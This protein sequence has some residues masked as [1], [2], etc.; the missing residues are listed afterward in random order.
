MEVSN[1]DSSLANGP[2]KIVAAQ[3]LA[4][5]FTKVSDRST[6]WFRSH[7]SEVYNCHVP[8]DDGAQSFC[9]VSNPLIRTSA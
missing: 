1:R 8:L 3:N 5:K 7:H 9:D 6:R 4:S 2:V